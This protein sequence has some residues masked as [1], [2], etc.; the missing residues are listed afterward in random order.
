MKRKIKYF[1]FVIVAVLCCFL[2]AHVDKTYDMYNDDVETTGCLTIDS[3][4]T[5]NISQSFVAKE[6]SLDGFSI[7]AVV[8]G[9]SLKGELLYTLYNE[10]NEKLFEG[11]TPLSE[12]KSGRI[13]KI[14]FGETIETKKDDLYIVS[15]QVSG[16]DENENVGLYYVMDEESNTEL[17]LD[18]ENVEGTLILRTVTFRLDIETFIVSVGIILY[19]VI[20]F[21]I[22]YKLFS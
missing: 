3:K 19:F 8:G 1:I 17:K 22:L 5:T 9:S 11:N 15:F 12:I 6:E 16:L 7:K 4:E 14:K 2:Y 18:N 20:F 13:N 10:E 21:K